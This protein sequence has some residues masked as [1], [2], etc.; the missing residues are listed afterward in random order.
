MLQLSQL[1]S[2]SAFNLAQVEYCSSE[3]HSCSQQAR[4]AL[5]VDF[6]SEHLAVWRL[7]ICLWCISV[8]MHSCSFSLFLKTALC[9]LRPPGR[10]ML[11]ADCTLEN[12]CPWL[13]LFSIII[14]WTL[15]FRCLKWI[16]SGAECFVMVLAYSVAGRW[17]SMAFFYLPHNKITALT[18]QPLHSKICLIP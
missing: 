17:G 8:G 16:C 18:H 14:G 5:S 12:K 4:N 1:H 10:I 11:T 13:W 9:S 6:L 3:W 2:S 15:H 7:I